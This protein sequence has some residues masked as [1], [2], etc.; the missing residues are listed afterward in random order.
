MSHDRDIPHPVKSLRCRGNK[1]HA[2]LKIS[3]CFRIGDGH[4]N[5]KI[6][7]VR[8]RGIPFVTI[9]DIIIPV[10]Y[11]CGFQHDRI[12]TWHI[13]LSHGK[14]GSDISSHQGIKITLFLFLGSM[15]VK[16]F[17]IACIRGLAPEDIMT[18]GGSTQRFGHKTVLKQ[19]KP[20]SPAFNREVGCPQLHFF[21][22]GLFFPE[23]GQKV[24]KILCQKFRFKGDEFFFHKFIYHCHN[25]L[26][27]F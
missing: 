13:H 25:G 23:Y 12:G 2:G 24:F 27:L 11:C 26:N 22:H 9:D 5:G 19:G 6:C 4:D 18:Q 14:T 15:E 7:P 17:N 21:D 1:N 20:H 10:L 16:D 3:G 8:C